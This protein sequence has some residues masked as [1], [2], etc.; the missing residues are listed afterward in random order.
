TNQVAA[1]NFREKSKQF[2]TF[3]HVRRVLLAR[4]DAA[5]LRH[6]VEE[7]WKFDQPGMNQKARITTELLHE[8]MQGHHSVP[9]HEAAMK[10]NQNRS[11]LSR[12]V[13]QPFHF[14]SPVVI[15]QEL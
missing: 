14:N 1:N 12:Y 3:Q 9:G 2:V 13:I 4:D 5:E 8:Q 11:S 10:A 6:V 7:K 15:V